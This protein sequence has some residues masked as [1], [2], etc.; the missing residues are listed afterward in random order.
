[1]S[2]EHKDFINF[3]RSIK[4]YKLIE[5]INQGGMGYIYLA[6]DT[7]LKRHVAINPAIKYF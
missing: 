6:E 7:R 5:L 1:M 2:L 4:Q 3:N